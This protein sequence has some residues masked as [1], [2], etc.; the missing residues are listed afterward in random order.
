MESS[1]ND[2]NNTENIDIKVLLLA[3]RDESEKNCYLHSLL[4]LISQKISL[5]SVLGF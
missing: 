2:H 5:S 4:Q 1:S 3:Y